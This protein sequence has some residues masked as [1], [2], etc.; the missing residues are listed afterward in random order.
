VSL[1]VTVT[2]TQVHDVDAAALLPRIRGLVL[3]QA[4]SILDDYGDVSIS[5]W[6]DWM[7]TIPANDEQIHLTLGEPRAAPSPTP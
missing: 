6:P 4:R 5:L 1:P 2:G 7:T 3:A